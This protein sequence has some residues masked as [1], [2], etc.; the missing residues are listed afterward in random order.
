MTER[1]EFD[2]LV[3]EWLNPNAGFFFRRG[4]VIDRFRSEYQQFEV[5]DT[6]EY[7]KLFRLDDFNMTSER[8]EFFY[9]ENLIHVPA[10]A[11]PQ[12][13]HG[14]I[15]GGG[16]G[17]AAEEMLKHPSLQQVTLVE[18]DQAVVDLARTHFH[19][20]HRGV[21]DSPRLRLLVTDGLKYVAE[22]ADRFDLIALDL[23]DPL[24]PSEALYSVEFF[25]QLRSILKTGGA[26]SLHIGSPIHHPARF[27]RL[28]KDLRRV[29]GAVTPY[30]VFIPLY[31]SLWGM[32]CA[33]DRLVPSLNAREVDVILRARG[34][35]D[36]QYINGDTYRGVLALPNFVRALIS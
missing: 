28:M 7:G 11:H 29:F 1:V 18:L 26:L 10:L 14:L 22:T 8:E 20:V 4:Q 12:P 24:G 34:M 31:G 2:D 13:T 25:T 9:H 35:T 3:L 23:T 33:S 21:F 30:L 19:A 36:L 17:G 6:P 32:A 16:D 15:I 5:Y 27:A